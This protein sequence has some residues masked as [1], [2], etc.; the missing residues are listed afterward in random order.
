MK[1]VLKTPKKIIIEVS[2][3]EMT[4]NGFDNVWDKIRSD[5]PEDV[6]SLH[7]VESKQEA[8]PSHLF[9]LIRI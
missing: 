1:I 2:D 5:Y 3:S 7:L 8:N 9:E 6:Y 4:K